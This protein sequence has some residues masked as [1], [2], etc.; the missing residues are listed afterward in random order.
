[1]TLALVLAAAL[2]GL[3]GGSA[4]ASSSVRADAALA[5][6]GVCAGDQTIGAAPA[7]EQATMA[8]LINWTRH[9]QG[10]KPVTPS[11]QLARAA[12]LKLDD[13]VSCNVFSHTACDLPK[14]TVFQDSGYLTGVRAYHL[15]ENLGWAQ[16]DLGS[17][18]S[19]MA[20]WLASPEHRAHLLDPRYRDLGVAYLSAPSFL[21][22]S[23]AQLWAAELGLRSR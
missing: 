2:V 15:G 1:M 13:N 7:A 10:L 6:L 4:S 20:A 14:I 5:P 21:G 19:I 3:G 17:P 8:C 9:A 22:Y 18:R 23:G 16:N 12:Q 11:P